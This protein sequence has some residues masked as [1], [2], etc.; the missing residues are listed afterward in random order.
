M[1]LTVQNHQMIQQENNAMMRL[2][3]D[4]QDLILRNEENSHMN[5]K[6]MVEM[7]IAEVNEVERHDKNL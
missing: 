3:F 1:G 4:Y 6:I 5:H 2:T 7:Y